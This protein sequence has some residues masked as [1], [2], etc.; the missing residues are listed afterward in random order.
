MYV[1]II[2]FFTKLGLFTSDSYQIS[3]APFIQFTIGAFNVTPFCV[4]ILSLMKVCVC[5]FAC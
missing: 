3:V 5:Y 4:E 1:G 2:I